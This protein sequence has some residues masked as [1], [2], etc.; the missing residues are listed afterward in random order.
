MVTLFFLNKAIQLGTWLGWY[1]YVIGFTNPFSNWKFDECTYFQWLC[2]AQV[3]LPT[4]TYIHLPI[5]YV[6]TYLLPVALPRAGT[7][8]LAHLPT[9]RPIPM[10]ITYLL[11]CLPTDSPILARRAS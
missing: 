2:L 9:Y 4:S 6:R 5:P 11:A 8:K 3:H 10:P 7:Y 1:H